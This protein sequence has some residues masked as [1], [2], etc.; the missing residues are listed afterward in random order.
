MTTNNEGDILTTTTGRPGLRVLRRAGAGAHAPRIAEPATWPQPVTML[1][2]AAS[3]DPDT[4]PLPAVTPDPPEPAWTSG[5]EP[6]PDTAMITLTGEADRFALA[7]GFWCRE[8]H[9]NPAAIT[10]PDLFGALRDSAYAAGWRVDLLGRWACPACQN[11]PAFLTR[12]VLAVPGHDPAVHDGGWCPRCVPVV[13][14]ARIADRLAATVETLGQDQDGAWTVTLP[15]SEVQP[16][17]PPYKHEI[18]TA[19][20]SLS[21]AARFRSDAMWAF[22]LGSRRHMRHARELA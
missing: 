17:Q 1:Q 9:R 19:F 16:G 14:Y 20:T 10:R 6:D 3:R 15:V 11:K 8:L 18:T 13:D 7:C 2:P 22:A 5:P 4:A 12:M 21:A